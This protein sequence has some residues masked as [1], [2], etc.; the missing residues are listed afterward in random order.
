VIYRPLSVNPS[1][2][3]GLWATSSC[4][5]KMFFVDQC[6]CFKMPPECTIEENQHSRSFNNK[7]AHSFHFVFTLNSRAVQSP[8]IWCR[9]RILF[10]KLTM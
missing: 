10:F 5:K 3:V 4:C 9:Q 1:L 2:V 8:F 6:I 7:H